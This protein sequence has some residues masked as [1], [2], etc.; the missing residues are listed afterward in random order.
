MKKWKLITLICSAILLVGIAV[1]LVVIFTDKNESDYKYP[2]VEPTLSNPSNVCLE[3]GIKKVT[4]K[5]LYDLGLVSYGL[6][7]LIDLVDDMI[8]NVEVTNAEIEEHRKN[9]YA[10]YNEIELENVDL[11]DKEQ[12]EKFIEQM[13]YQG[14]MTTAEIDAAIKLDIKRNKLAEQMLKN[15]IKSFVPVKDDEGNVIQD[16]YFNEVQISNAILSKCPD[17]AKLIYLT[18]RSS[19]EALQLMDEFDI[20]RNARDNGWVHKSTGKAFTKEEIIDTFIAMYNKVNAEDIVNNSYP[21]YTQKELAEISS[22]LASNIFTKLEDIN[23]CSSLKASMTTSPKQYANGYYYLAVKISTEKALTTQQFIEQFKANNLSENAKLV[24]DQLI[25]STLS[26]S[27][28]NTYLYK[29]RFDAGI[30]IYDEGLDIKYTNSSASAMKGYVEMYQGTKEESS[31][32]V[33][34]INSNGQEKNITADQL[35]DALLKRY[36]SLLATEF[37]NRYMAF[38]KVYSTVYDYET[39]TKLDKF[40]AFENAEILSYKAA[41]EDGSLE[42]YGYPKNYGWTNFI[43]DYF[44]VQNEA[45]LILIG[46]AYNLAYQNYSLSTFKLTNDVVNEIYEKFHLAYELTRE[47]VNNITIKEFE[48]FL[49]TKNKADYENTLVYQMMNSLIKYFD[50]KAGT[51]KFYVDVNND[52][53]YDDL[54]DSTK[55]LGITLIDAF[56]AIASNSV[57][58]L[59]DGSVKALANNI[60]N[61][62]EK[63][64]FSPITSITG[65]T[66]G[67]RLYS[68][69]NLYNN[70]SVF[71]STL[72]VYK[73]AGIRLVID[74]ESSYTDESTDEELA[75]LLKD[76]WNQILRKE[77]I[78]NGEAV[79]FPYTEYQ[80]TAVNAKP[81]E[82]I[83][84]ANPYRIEEHYATENSVSVVF[85]TGAT[86]STWY[87]YFTD[88]VKMFPMTTVDN[89]LVIDSTRVQDY[90]NYY[91]LSERSESYLTVEESTI[92]KNIGA[93]STYQKNYINN[94]L[95]AAHEVLAGDER[96]SDSMYNY[97]KTA[98][99]NGTIKFSGALSKD[100]YLKLLDVI[101]KKD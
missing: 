81:A 97:R 12:T 31:K 9:L 25:D 63:G 38:N 5:E 60:L 55:Q 17:K 87:N 61:A 101:Y 74:T 95:V 85:V 82:G 19:S 28:I 54:T 21:T 39:A 7:A 58:S 24:Y 57:D 8:I 66:I 35:L 51:L 91:I 84:T 70:C 11:E 83:S 2:T 59:N 77:L 26:S 75:V 15:D 29:N 44:G 94:V 53:K 68:L 67:D 42:T 16:F 76:V 3:V 13:N 10:A 48:E 69:V 6:T 37:I 100:T 1:L 71:A 22:T 27:L 33:L 40:T 52:T 41:L 90:L 34:T 23:T 80:N 99:N 79:Y 88:S 72:K 20:S 4:Y 64:E 78:I 36:G 96:I 50:V 18:F 46:E 30:K 49:A 56:Y 93:L 47:D 43:T 98:I 14:Y 92:L 32:Y 65:E 89:K 73:D 45:E 62:L 86:N